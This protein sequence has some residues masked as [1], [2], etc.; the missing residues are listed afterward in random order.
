MC[1]EAG[2]HTEA[3]FAIPFFQ[4]AVV[5]QLEIILDDERHEIVLQLFLEEDQ[6]AD[7]AISVLEGM[8][9]LKCHMEYNDILEGLG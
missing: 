8:D 3:F 7:T 5:E 1:G 2:V 4:A 6:P 9:A